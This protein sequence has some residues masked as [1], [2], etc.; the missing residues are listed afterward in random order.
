MIEK[1][2]LINRTYYLGTCRNTKIAMWLNDDFI[3]INF[4]FHIP[5]IEHV[6]H[7]SDVKD[8]NRDGFIPIKIV[9]IEYDE[10]R[11]A[12]DEQDYKNYYRKIYLNI[13]PESI[14]GEIWK[15]VVNYEGLYEVSNYGRIK[16]I[17]NNTIC[18]QNFCRE[19]LVLGL[20]KNKVRN[21]ELWDEQN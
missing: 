9:D 7:Y 4:N 10:I 21:E 11:M 2:D 12:K 5:Y 15:N 14:N 18:K 17:S 6:K 1:K 16:K 19:Y 3:F 13:N 20:T 8:I